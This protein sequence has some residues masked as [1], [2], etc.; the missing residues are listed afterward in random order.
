MPSC[1]LV[2]DCKQ[3]QV[4]N[5]VK[6]AQGHEWALN[7]IY[8]THQLPSILPTTPPR[9]QGDEHASPLA[10]TH[11]LVLTHEPLALRLLVV[12]SQ[13]K[14]PR[15]KTFFFGV[16]KSQCHEHLC[17]CVYLDHFACSCPLA[18]ACAFV[19]K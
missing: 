17:P 14:P 1:E 4:G 19:K 5:L 7:T 13:C 18:P 16:V 2:Q 8:I 10:P 3:V 9:V 11:A 15:K 12:H 6:Q